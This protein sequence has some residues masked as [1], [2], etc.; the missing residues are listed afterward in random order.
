VVVG[1]KQHSRVGG[2]PPPP[3]QKLDIEK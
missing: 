2:G 1:E 3:P